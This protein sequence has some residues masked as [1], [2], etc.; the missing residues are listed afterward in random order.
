MRIVILAGGKSKRM[1]V[2][3]PILKVGGK[4]MLL[5]VYEEAEKAGKPVVA[6][7]DNAPMTRR[8]CVER[9]MD[10]IDTPGKGYVE[11]VRYLLSEFPM[12][13]SV[14]ADLPFVMERDF[15]EI[16]GT[17]RAEKVNLTG[18]VPENPD[19]PP[20]KH[21]LSSCIRCGRFVVVGLNTV[22]AKT[23][24]EN[25]AILSNPLLV[26][27]VNSPADLKVADEIANLK[28]MTEKF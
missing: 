19:I 10:T 6:V 7:S 16:I 14:S 8:F 13:V 21:F 20:L 28:T 23:E 3:K 5:R 22:T 15:E 25:L 11:D 18:V 17:F 24:R 27:N 12:F 2:E 9:G 26:V 4:E 1:G